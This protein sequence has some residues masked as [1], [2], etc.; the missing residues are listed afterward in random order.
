VRPGDIVEIVY[1][2]ER[3]KVRVLAVTAWGLRCW[4]EDRSAIRGFCFGKIGTE[5]KLQETDTAAS[6]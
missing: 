4:D 2:G 1:E 3:R 6:G 5:E